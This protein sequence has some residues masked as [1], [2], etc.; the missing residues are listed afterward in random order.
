MSMCESSRYSRQK[1]QM[2]AFSLGARLPLGANGRLALSLPQSYC[3]N[4]LCSPTAPS[5]EGAEAA[6]PQSTDLAL[7]SKFGVN[8]ITG[9]RYNPSVNPLNPERLDSSPSIRSEAPSFI[10]ARAAKPLVFGAKHQTQNVVRQSRTNILPKIHRGAE[11]RSPSP[12]VR[13]GEPRNTL[14]CLCATSSS[15]CARTAGT[16]SFFMR[17]KGALHAAEPRFIPRRG[18][19]CAIACFICEAKK[20]R[21]SINRKTGINLAVPLSL[22][23][24]K[25]PLAL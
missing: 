7:L 9:R 4:P 10:V 25:A 1:K 24:P 13:T 2:T 12:S 3:L 22:A 20:S 18:A 21:L 23:M 11:K 15:K 17:P 16:H 19:S 5:S 8:A 6:P 14:S